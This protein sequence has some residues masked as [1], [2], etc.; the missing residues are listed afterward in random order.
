MDYKDFNFSFS[1][2]E[3]EYNRNLDNAAI[4]NWTET[5][6]NITYLANYIINGFAFC[7]CFKHKGANFTNKEKT[8]NNLLSANLVCID[9]DAVKYTFNDFCALMEK[10][11]INPNIVYTTANNGKF[12]DT[13][14]EKYNNR[15]RV[16]FVI[17][18]SITNKELYTQIH[19]NLKKEIELLTEDDNIFNDN[20]DKSVSHFFA[21]N[22]DCCIS[23]D[24][25]VYSLDWLIKRYGI[26]NKNIE[27]I[28]QYNNILENKES[29]TQLNKKE[30][31][32]ESIIHLYDT[33]SENEKQFIKDYWDMPIIE[34][35]P[36]YI[37]NYPSIECTQINYDDSEPYIMLPQNYIEIKRRWYKED[38]TKD[39]GQ[40][41][42]LSNIHKTRNGEGRR[43]LLFINLLLRKRILP[44]ISFCHLLFN[45]VYEL[46]YYIN[47][48]DK[49]DKI[50]KKQ[51]YKITFNAFMAEDKLKNLE[52][53]K[54]KINEKYCASH[55]VNKIQANISLINQK[56]LD[57]KQK[58]L[59]KV[60]E[61]YDT[62]LTDKENHLK[63]YDSGLNI[64]FVTFKRYKKE[65]GLIKRSNKRFQKDITEKVDKMP[66]NEEINAQNEEKESIKE[67]INCLVNPTPTKKIMRVKRRGRW[68]L[69]PITQ[70]KAIGG[71]MFTC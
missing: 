49:N 53:R 36:K 3:K 51:I 47:N 45:A 37:K 12:K 63:L 68:G 10:T 31:E 59:E 17:D 40:V 46:N 52:K 56:K 44:N 24:C 19:Q 7:N 9:L 70:S 43:N 11:E 32:G 38:V 25:Y 6:G 13:K 18:K 64:S 30:E 34:L 33:F 26:I 71:D 39:N 28:N 60:K 57:D 67:E 4:I 27:S 62:E 35:I 15:Y 1:I 41:V 2:S 55:N 21:G 23:M 65:L 66:T 58:N 61:L 14:K 22:K 16:I 69:K 5:R 54:Y 29:I 50:T 42:K 20:S 48:T 8:D